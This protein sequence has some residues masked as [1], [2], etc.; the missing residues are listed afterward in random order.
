MLTKVKA[1]YGD[2]NVKAEAGALANKW[3]RD[4]K[5]QKEQAALAAVAGPSSRRRR[6]S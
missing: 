1:E 6:R 2:A 5:V 4:I 3:L